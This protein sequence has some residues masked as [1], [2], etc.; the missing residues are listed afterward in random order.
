MEGGMKT[1]IVQFSAEADLTP[2]IVER[3][4]DDAAESPGP[5]MELYLFGGESITVTTSNGEPVIDFRNYEPGLGTD[6]IIGDHYD[7]QSIHQ[8]IFR[9]YSDAGRGPVTHYL[10]QANVASQKSYRDRVAAFGAFREDSRESDILVDDEMLRRRGIMSAEQEDQDFPGHPT[11]LY[12]DWDGKVEDSEVATSLRLWRIGPPDTLN[13][14]W[15]DHRS[16]NNGTA[17]AY[18][19][20]WTEPL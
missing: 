16:I 5:A 18:E 13:V 12:V 17:I 7:R 8:E 19:P 2:D 6:T 15:K 14:T 4:L 10:I 9:A 11:L 20:R 3:W 1:G